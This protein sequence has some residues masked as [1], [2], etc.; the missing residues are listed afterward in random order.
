MF[1]LKIV[2][3]R[4]IEIFDVS[5]HKDYPYVILFYSSSMRQICI[6]K[7]CLFLKAYRSTINK[8]STSSITFL[9]T[10]VYKLRAL[11]IMVHINMKS[12]TISDSGGL[13]SRQ[14]P[15]GHCFPAIIKAASPYNETDLGC[16]YIPQLPQQLVV[17]I[18]RNKT[19]RLLHVIKIYKQCHLPWISWQV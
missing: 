9:Y 19:L 8:P 13:P 17:N 5:K 18:L 16:F 12:R 3:L 6:D 14:W 2:W 4:Y 10:N 15:H 7:F 11:K 1:D